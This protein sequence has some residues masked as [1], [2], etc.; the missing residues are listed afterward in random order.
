MICTTLCFYL[1][2]EYFPHPHYHYFTYYFFIVMGRAPSPSP[3]AAADPSSTSESSDGSAGATIGWTVGFL[4]GILVASVAYWLYHRQNRN[5]LTTTVAISTTAAAAG[6]SPGSPGLRSSRDSNSTLSDSNPPRYIFKP[7]SNRYNRYSR[8]TNYHHSGGPDSGPGLGFERSPLSANRSS[9]SS[10]DDSDSYTYYDDNDYDYENSREFEKND[11][12]DSPGAPVPVRVI[13]G[14]TSTY[15][16]S[17]SSSSSSRSRGSRSEL[18][19][20]WREMFDD[21]RQRRYYVNLSEKRSQWRRPRTSSRPALPPPTTQQQPR[22]QY[23]PRTAPS[24]LVVLPPLVEARQPGEQHAQDAPSKSPSPPPSPPNNGTQ[25]APTARPLLP[26]PS[27]SARAISS[28]TRTSDINGPQIA[29]ILPEGWRRL[30]S[31]ERGRYYYANKAAGVSQWK[32]PAE[33]D[34]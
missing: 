4:L 34:W 28:R 21:N 1:F 19:P 18:P 7:S 26:A 23:S 20:G 13:S 17:S 12:P 22:R 24:A 11:D 2:S 8:S 9:S 30:W 15:N 32:K 16:N 6:G 29:D 3:S 33:A 27:P 5:K 25:T 14:Q 10:S 31:E